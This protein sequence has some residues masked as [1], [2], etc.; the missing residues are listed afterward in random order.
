MLPVSV[1]AGILMTHTGRYRWCLW[2]GWP[3]TTLA[4]GLLILL[5][6]DT[7]TAVWVI[8]LIVAGVGHGFL[9]GPG[10]FAAQ[11]TCTQDDA[12]VA[13]SVYSFLRSFGMCLGVALGGTVFQN[14]LKARLAD[15][16]LPA[17][18]ATDAAAYAQRLRDMQDA[19]TKPAVRQM[20]QDDFAQ[21][22]QAVMALLTGV[23]AGGFFLSAFIKR[24]LD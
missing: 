23:G 24:V 7:K 6:S 17:W 18:I 1:I 22:F 14:G 21:G 5:N 3:L 10:L 9:L 8:L 12:A 13:T 11:T 19:G 4:S 16:G 2:V 20:I 15:D